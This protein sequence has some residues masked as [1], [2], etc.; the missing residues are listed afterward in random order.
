MTAEWEAKLSEIESG[1]IKPEMFMKNIQLYVQKCVS[2]YGSVD[3]DNQIASQKRNI[4]K[5]K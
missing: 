2:D 5:R 3:K 4:Q 1:K